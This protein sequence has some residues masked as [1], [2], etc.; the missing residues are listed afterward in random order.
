MLLSEDK[1]SKISGYD[2]I[3]KVSAHLEPLLAHYSMISHF[4]ARLRE[5]VHVKCEE[6]I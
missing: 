3:I 2:D 1:T 5:S 4:K 6:L